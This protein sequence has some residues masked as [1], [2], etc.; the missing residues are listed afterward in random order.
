MRCQDSETVPA[1]DVDHTGTH[2]DRD[3]NGGDW[4]G[5][6]QSDEL[7]TAMRRYRGLFVELGG[8]GYFVDGKSA[9]IKMGVAEEWM[10]GLVRANQRSAL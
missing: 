8:A 9:P 7:F 10:G 3:G 4:L 5:R 6:R 1:L 2:W